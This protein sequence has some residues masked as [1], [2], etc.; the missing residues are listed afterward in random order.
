M[1]AHIPVRFA[2]NIM[3]NQYRTRT[4]GA[5]ITYNLV[6]TVHSTAFYH[7]RIPLSES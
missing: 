1:L 6:D 7:F 5:S 2:D 3:F 4:S